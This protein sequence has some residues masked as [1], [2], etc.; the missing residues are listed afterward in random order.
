M[1]E[2]GGQC[3]LRLSKEVM[4]ATESIRVCPR[5]AEWIRSLGDTDKVECIKGLREAD[6][7]VLGFAD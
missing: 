5:L 2:R 1:D 6:A 3:L 7:N 4:T